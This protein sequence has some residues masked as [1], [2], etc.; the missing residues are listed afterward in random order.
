MADAAV[1]SDLLQKNPG[2]IRSYLPCIVLAVT[3]SEPASG[4]FWAGQRSLSWN[5]VPYSLTLLIQFSS[6]LNFT[7]ES[8]LWSLWLLLCCGFSNHS[9]CPPVS[10]EWRGAIEFPQL[11]HDLNC[12][13]GASMEKQLVHYL[14]STGNQPYEAEELQFVL[15]GWEAIPCLIGNR[16]MGGH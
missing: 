5:P 13:S 1:T 2:P 15:R 4:S 7:H 9:P 11:S 3:A 14:L 10:L 16:I 6:P 8:P 12:H